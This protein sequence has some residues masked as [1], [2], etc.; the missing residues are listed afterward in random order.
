VL[1]LELRLDPS[2]QTDL[3]PAN[4]SKVE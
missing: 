1:Y 4:S 3:T 2:H